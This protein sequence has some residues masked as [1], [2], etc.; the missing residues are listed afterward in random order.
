MKSFL[1]WLLILAATYSFGS[2]LVQNQPP[3]RYVW[4]D[5]E[6][7]FLYLPSVFVHGNFKDYRVRTKNQFKRFPGTDKIFTKYTC[8]VAML[9]APFFLA[10]YV[11]RWVQGFE[12]PGFYETEDY[13]VAML[14][15]ACFYGVLG[16]FFVHKT[17][18][19]HFENPWAARLTIALLLLGTNLLHYMVRAPG[20]PH[21]YSFFL[22]SLLIYLTPGIFEKPT[23][24]RFFAAG[25]LLGWLVLIRP[26][27]AVLAI[28][29]LLYGFTS[30][31]AV[32]E[33]LL[34][35]KKHL[36]KILLAAL[37]AF[38]IWLPQLMYWHYVTGDWIYY[39]YRKEGFNNWANP[40]IHKV[41]F[42]PLNGWLLY[43]PAMLFALAGMPFLLKN[44][45]HNGWAVLLIFAFSTY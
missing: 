21:V 24:W 9:E 32:A 42:S 14:M 20:M 31:K 34:F 1:A 18:R 12:D 22:A 11:S 38:L 25:G 37:P 13:G 17:L 43:N 8:G 4:S 19:R 15:G 29:P 26:T 7:Y 33:R 40:P 16:L 35:F 44:N 3:N 36:P 41:F 23:W 2:Y 10:A 28:F 39:S 30:G 27:N 5:A 6:G 45:R